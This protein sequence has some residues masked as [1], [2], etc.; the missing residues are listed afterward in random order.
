MAS[1]V[2]DFVGSFV[3]AVLGFLALIKIIK[4]ARARKQVWDA[5]K[6]FEENSELKRREG[7]SVSYGMPDIVGNVDDRKVYIHPVRSKKG[8]KPMPA[9][10]IYAV[11]SDIDVN[12]NVIISSPETT[13]QDPDLA[14]LEIPKLKR[15]G[16][17]VHTERYDNQKAVEQMVSKDVANKINRLVVKHGDDFRALILEPGIVMFSTFKIDIDPEQM[18]EKLREIIKLVESME[19]RHPESEESIQNERLEEVEKTS[20][21]VYADMVIMTL[22]IAASIYIIYDSLKGMSFIFMNLGMVLSFLAGARLISIVYTRGWLE[23]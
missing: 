1:F 23:S 8:K 3:L 18:K 5:F 4:S 19:D 20:K 21:T 6:D 11:E 2:L 7:L 15:Y 22:V 13:E 16:L 17:K 14:K 10:T 9:K 12:K